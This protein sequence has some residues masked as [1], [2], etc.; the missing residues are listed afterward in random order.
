MSNTISKYTADGLPYVDTLDGPV[1]LGALPPDPKFSVGELFST[2]FNAIPTEQWTANSLRATAIPMRNQKQFGSCA[3]QA[4]VTALMIIRELRGLKKTILSATFIYGLCNGG[5]DGGSRVTDCVATVQNTGTCLESQVPWDV[6]YKTQFPQEAF[7][8]AKRY[9]AL[10][11][12]KLSSYEE[13]CTALI[14]G[15]PCVSGI[16]VGKNF[17]MNQIASDGLAPLP[18]TIAGGH[19]MCH[20][21]LKKL[22]NMWVIET[23]NSWGTTWGINGFCYLQKGHFNPNYGYGFDVYAIGS[24]IDDPEDVSDDLH[25]IKK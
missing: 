16:A 7:T 8:T 24:A 14:L 4:V 5:R 19:A 10:E 15:F 18:D 1:V 25:P 17:T 9:K 22:R 20:I 13:L 6:I 2:S 23:Q 3:G 21:G 12:Y 11:V